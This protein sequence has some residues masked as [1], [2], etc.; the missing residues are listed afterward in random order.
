MVCPWMFDN[1]HMQHDGVAMDSPLGPVFADICLCVHEVLWLEKY[2]PE[3]K[4]MIYKRYVNDTVLLFQNINQIEKFKYY[5]NLQHAN[6][7]FTS[8]IEIYNSGLFLKIKI[9]QKTTNLLPQFIVSLHSMVFLLALR[10]LYP[11]YT[12]A[13]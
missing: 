4:P 2:P 6:I 1:E 9:L 8:E 11:I 5:L 10:V 3:F 13:P 12:N 7:K